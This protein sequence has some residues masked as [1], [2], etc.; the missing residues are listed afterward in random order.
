M[1]IT[2]EDMFALYSIFYLKL[3]KK[4][5]YKEFNIKEK[6]TAYHVSRKFLKQQYSKQIG[7]KNLFTGICRLVC[8][9]ILL[10]CNRQPNLNARP[11]KLVGTTV[12]VLSNRPTI[13]SALKP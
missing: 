11:A 12:D 13:T 3:L 2:V 8:G 9:F 1:R 7:N 4:N 5:Y 10:A 6:I